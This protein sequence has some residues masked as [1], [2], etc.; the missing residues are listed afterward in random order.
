MGFSARIADAGCGNGQ[1]LYELYS[2]E[3]SDLDGFDPY[4]EKD[5]QIA[6]GIKIW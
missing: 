5:I 4:I 2:G 3:Y 1:L 6:P